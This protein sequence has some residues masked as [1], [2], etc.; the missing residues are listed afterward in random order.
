MAL[1]YT[2][3]ALSMAI[4]VSLALF[5]YYISSLEI[6]HDVLSVSKICAIVQKN[7]IF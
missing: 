7:S 1:V 5:L 2:I 6:G 3:K 4:L